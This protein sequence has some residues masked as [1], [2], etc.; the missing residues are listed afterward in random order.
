MTGP[1]L[2]MRNLGFLWATTIP[3]FRR[4]RLYSHARRCWILSQLKKSAA[5]M[6]EWST[7]ISIPFTFI[8]AIHIRSKTVSLRTTVAV[9]S[10]ERLSYN[11]T[12][13][14]ASL[15][16]AFFLCFEYIII[17][18]Y[19]NYCCNSTH[20]GKNSNNHCWN[21]NLVM[22]LEAFLDFHFCWLTLESLVYLIS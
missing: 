20:R 5:N 13:I 14:V 15:R 3:K 12:A 10:I 1:L 8:Y 16:E 6:R 9:G 22:F 17:N 2:K 7:C 11:Q 19:N 4:S 18:Y 21:D